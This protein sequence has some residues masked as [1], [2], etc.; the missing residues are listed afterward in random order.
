MEFNLNTPIWLQL[1]DEFYRRISI[2]EWSPGERIPSVRNLATELKVNP[3]TVQKSLLEMERRGVLHTERTSGR[4]LTDQM[5][6]IAEL[7]YQHA[8][9]FT[10]TYISQIH[11]MDFSLPEVQEL[12]AKHWPQA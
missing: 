3:N 6:R 8:S 1:I 7:R 11:G 10:K 4:F 9:N 5:E 12:V 2:G